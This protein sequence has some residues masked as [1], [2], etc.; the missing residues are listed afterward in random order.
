MEPAKPWRVLAAIHGL[1][2]LAVIFAQTAASTRSSIRL[3][4]TLARAD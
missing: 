4:E 2:A 3:L 1:I